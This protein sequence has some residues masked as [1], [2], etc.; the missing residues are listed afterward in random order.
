[1]DVTY[2]V[3]GAIKR[4]A[5]SRRKPWKFATQVCDLYAEP[6]SCEEKKIECAYDQEL[7]NFSLLVISYFSNNVLVG[8]W[9]TH[10]STA[11]FF[12]HRNSNKTLNKFWYTYA[13]CKFK[14]FKLPCL[15]GGFLKHDR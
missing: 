8:Y 11:N 9:G 3:L 1:M 6:V 7:T 10:S 5:Y 2:V 4:F 14:K 15:H 12:P 13:T